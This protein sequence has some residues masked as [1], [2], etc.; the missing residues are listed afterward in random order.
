MANSGKY[1]EVAGG[2]IVESYQK[3]YSLYSDQNIDTIAA[4]TIEQEGREE[5]IAFGTPET[6]PKT[7]VLSLEKIAVNTEFYVCN[8]SIKNNSDIANFWVLEDSGKVF[9]WLKRRTNPDDIKKPNPLP[10]TLSGNNTFN[11]KATFVTNIATSGMTI[12]VQDESKKYQ[13][14]LVRQASTSKNVPF[15]V[16][17]NSSN[18]PYKNLIQYLPNFKLVFDYTTDGKT[19]R[20]LNSAQFCLYLSWKKPDF[21]KFNNAHGMQLTYKGKGA[22]CETLLW[23]GCAPCSSLPTVSN[24]EKLIDKVFEKFKTLKV[25]RRREGSSYVSPNWSKE[26][27]GYW[28]GRSLTQAYQNNRGLKMFLIDGE[29]RCGEWTIFFQHILLSQGLSVGEDTVGICTQ[30]AT[31]MGF[32]VNP[33]VPGSYP[34]ITP[35]YKSN[36]A[37]ITFAVK[38]A[39][40]NNLSN[41]TSTSGDSA[42]QGTKTARPFFVDH[43]WF[44]YIKGKRFYDASYG[45]SYDSTQSRLK[46]YCAD[47]LGSVYTQDGSTNA[48]A[49][50]KTNLHDWVRATKN[51]F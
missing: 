26:G 18:T 42:G 11:F 22:I 45:K 51:L 50:V 14:P 2:K 44:Y 31:S 39:V 34:Y 17:F 33:T 20:P 30:Y 24:E 49:I 13:F 28:R 8:D 32:S 48:T 1:T 35:P 5:G 40:H 7:E 19:W 15:E 3:D 46:K 6:A 38:S 29:A 16:Q 23:L 47:N 12:R 36:P 9:H 43:F 25:I 10:I 37:S 4:T 27:L 21:A 41:P